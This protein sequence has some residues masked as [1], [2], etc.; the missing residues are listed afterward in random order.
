MATFAEKPGLWLREACGL[1]NIL[2][3]GCFKITWEVLSPDSDLLHVN[4]ITIG[5]LL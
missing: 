5:G 3:S 4:A 1:A 2:H